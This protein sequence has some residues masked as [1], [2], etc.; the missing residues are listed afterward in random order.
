MT[1]LKEKDTSEETLDLDMDLE[2]VIAFTIHW[3]VSLREMG[4]CIFYYAMVKA[5]GVTF[6]FAFEAKIWKEGILLIW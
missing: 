1:D 5:E 3:V 4:E 6:Y 2:L